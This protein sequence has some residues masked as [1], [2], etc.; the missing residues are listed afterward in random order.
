[1]PES[2]SWRYCRL[3]RSGDFAEYAGAITETKIATTVAAMAVPGRVNSASPLEPRKLP[4]NGAAGV[5]KIAAIKAMPASNRTPRASYRKNREVKPTTPAANNGSAATSQTPRLNSLRRKVKKS[6]ATV[7]T[8]EGTNITKLMPCVSQA[9][10]AD[11]S[12]HQIHAPAHKPQKPAR[13][14]KAI[15]NK[16]TTDIASDQNAICG[17]RASDGKFAGKNPTARKT[18]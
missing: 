5:N 4:N 1:L 8:Q 17:G 3:T 16:T 14:A 11:S 13:A 18:K 2:L 10:M 15:D 9:M 7:A 6:P 12:V